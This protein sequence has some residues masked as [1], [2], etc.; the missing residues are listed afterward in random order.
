MLENAFER[1]VSWTGFIPAPVWATTWNHW[2]SILAGIQILSMLLLCVALFSLLDGK[3]KDNWVWI[4][5]S[6]AVIIA[7]FWFWIVIV[8]VIIAAILFLGIGSVVGFFNEK[9]HPKPK[10]VL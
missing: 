7:P 3:W 5:I 6:I 1:L 9:S 10:N 2:E 4:P 8:F